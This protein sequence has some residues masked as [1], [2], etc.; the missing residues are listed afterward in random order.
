M[1][2]RKANGDSAASK[3]NGDKPSGDS[4]SREPMYVDLLDDNGQLSQWLLGA[5]FLDYNSPMTA[6][7]R[8][9]TCD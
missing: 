4:K 2:G 5:P 3:A 8:C 6:L 1:H 7:E 9:C